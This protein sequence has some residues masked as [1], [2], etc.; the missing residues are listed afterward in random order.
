MTPLLKSTAAL[1]HIGASVER[2]SELT[3]LPH[4]KRNGG[5]NRPPNMY[6]ADHVE[7][8]RQLHVEARLPLTAAI[9][10][11]VAE[12]EGRLPQP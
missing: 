7:R 8:V 11:V 2:A 3:G 5:P 6:R 4:T 12:I 1:E 10:V 9:R